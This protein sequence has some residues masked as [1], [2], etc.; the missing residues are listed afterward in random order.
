MFFCIFVGEDGKYEVAVPER[1]GPS[2]LVP[3]Y[4]LLIILVFFALGPL[5]VL[6]F[7]SVKDSASI[8]RNPLGPPT[9]FYWQ[10]YP[11][12]W[13]IGQFLH[14][15]GQQHYLGNRNRISG[16]VSGRYGSLQSGPAQ[17]SR[18]RRGDALSL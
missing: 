11:Q 1:A 7:N 9:E 2:D 15:D 18:W 4:I 17:G 13:E 16:S 5:I 14:H 3:N 12:A 6:V 10:N 8:G